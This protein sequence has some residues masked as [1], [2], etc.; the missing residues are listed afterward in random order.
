MVCV[1][2]GDIINYLADLK[3]TGEISVRD[4]LKTS[5]YRKWGD[6]LGQTFTNFAVFKDTAKLHFSVNINLYSTN[7]V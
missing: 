6:S 2:N 1:N 5:T 7:F 3:L 4:S